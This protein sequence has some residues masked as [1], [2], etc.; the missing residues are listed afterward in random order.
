MDAVPRT[1]PEVPIDMRVAFESLYAHEAENVYR[2]IY[3]IVLD[4][5]V[6]RDVLQETFAWAFEDWDEFGPSNPRVQLLQI[7]TTLA[8]A[9]EE[10]EQQ[11]R[12]PSSPPGHVGTDAGSDTSQDR[13]EV[14]RWLM[15]P[16][17]ADQRALIVLHLYQRVPAA[18]VAELLGLAVGTVAPRVSMAIQV[19]HQRALVWQS[20]VPS[21]RRGMASTGYFEPNADLNAQIIDA[22]TDGLDAVALTLPTLEEALDRARS[23]SP[24]H[25][26]RRALP[27][28]FVAAAVLLAVGATAL[29]VAKIAHVGNGPTQ[30]AQHSPPT[31]VQSAA[32]SAAPSASSAPPG[33]DAPSTP[34]AA[35]PRVTQTAAASP[36]ATGA[37]PSSSTPPPAPASQP[38]ASAP[39]TTTTSHSTSTPQ[40]TQSRGPL[41]TCG[42]LGVGCP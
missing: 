9:H 18:D 8:I 29:A 35:S 17:T 37:K 15:R 22:L 30:Q 2:T 25:G 26:E 27:K 41:P 3:G 5:G 4:G 14:V 13:D 20:A 23:E 32:P 38:P 12:Q 42:L 1:A 21:G 7:A 40:S 24:S 6:A 16:L 11:A 39:T 28:V 36:P 34:A 33:T 10:E 19:L 31:S